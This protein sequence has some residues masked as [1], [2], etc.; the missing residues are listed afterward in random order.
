MTKSIARQPSYSKGKSREFTSELYLKSEQ[1]LRFRI[2]FSL[3]S[4]CLCVG[5][6]S[7]AGGEFDF[8]RATGIICGVSI[9]SFV[10]LAFVVKNLKASSRKLQAFNAVLLDWLGSLDQA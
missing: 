2:A 5:L 4:L 6:Y 9:Y 8:Y 1:L 7:F 3:V 10:G